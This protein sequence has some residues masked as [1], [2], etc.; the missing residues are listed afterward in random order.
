MT[1]RELIEKLAQQFE[2][3]SLRDA[4]LVVE[5]IFEAMA[6]TLSQ[7]KRIEIRGFGSF[8]V[9][10]R[11]AKQSRNPKTGDRVE[12]KEK[13]VPFFKVGKELKAR[14]NKPKGEK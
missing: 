1:R 5:T 8:E 2:G 4:E 6:E 9:R 12:V 3:M 7:G 11:R 14:L 13:K 10:A